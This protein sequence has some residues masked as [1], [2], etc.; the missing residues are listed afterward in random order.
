MSK[1]HK[2][3]FGTTEKSNFILNMTNDQ[4]NKTAAVLFTI[5]FALIFVLSVVSEL[6]S[7]GEVS[8][9]TYDWKIIPSVALGITGILAVSIFIIALIKQTLTK[10]QII[11][12]VAVLVLTV[13]MYISYV[14]SMSTIQDY[15][16][17]LGYRYGRYE[18]LMVY[19]SY[20]FIFLGSLSVNTEKAVRNIFRIFPVTV[21][22][23]SI[24][25][26]LQFIPS[27][28]GH[29]Y[30][31]P[32]LMVNPMLPSG[33]AGS[34][35]FLATFMAAGVIVSLFGAFHDKSSG[36]RIICK[37]A[38]LAGSFF[39]VKTQ[40]LIGYASAVI[41]LAAA[42]ADSIKNKKDGNKDSSPL[43]LLV[44][45][46]AA[47]CAFI[48]IKGF[49]VYDGEVIWQDGCK[50]LSAFGQYSASMEGSINIHDIKE[51]YPYLWGKAYDIIKQFPVTGIGPDAFIFSQRKGTF[52]DVPLS[53]DRPYSEYLYY[54][55]TFGIPAAV[56]LAGLFFYSSANGVISVV[57]NK[58]WVFRAAMAA[59]VLYTVTAVITNSTATVTPY[60]WL[61]LGTC[62][63][64]L[65]DKEK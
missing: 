55:A 10:K 5:G 42:V 41:I 50:R 23:Q 59:A 29:Y 64:T 18:G 65:S 28:P 63:S 39:L 51:V 53:V 14:N 3:I 61:L 8:V 4:F 25:A 12:S 36:Y 1:T 38:V 45:G 47:A 7:N 17:F 9:A 33:T 35:A 46:F 58:S 27:F 30:K 62:C 32:Y 13:C 48:F 21:I 40:T 6:M 56:S 52:N 22:L 44:T 2:T 49:A 26:G 43:V 57:K 60:I 15:S 31:I 34:P 24:W 20:L 37:T 19:L 11:A 54:A 16:A